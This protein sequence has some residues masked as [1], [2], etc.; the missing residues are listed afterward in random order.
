MDGALSIAAS[1]MAANAAWLGRIASQVVQATTPP[2]ASAPP[3]TS[4]GNVASGTTVGSATVSMPSADLVSALVDQRLAL[5]NF[6]A[7]AAVFR[8]AEAMDKT[9]FSLVA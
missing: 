8:T 1:G 2:T 3:S 5:S 4:S 7:D 9:L 6:R